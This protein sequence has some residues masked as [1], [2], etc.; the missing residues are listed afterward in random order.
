MS[1]REVFRPKTGFLLSGCALTLSALFIWSALL[2]QGLGAAIAWSVA[3][4]ALIYMIYIRPKIIYDNVKIVIINPWEEISIGWGDI[5]L[6]D[7]KWCMNITSRHG[8]FSAWA[9][10]APSR[11]HSKKIHPSELRG[12]EISTHQSISPAR[13]PKSDSGIAVH[14]ATVRIKDFRGDS[15][16]FMYQKNWSW[17]V[18]VCLSFIAALVLTLLGK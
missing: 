13:S 2:T 18:L 5:N 4:N 12:M 7:A 11:F 17:A 8:R 9:A 1:E 6:V 3:I 14:M 16:E 15:S 10:P